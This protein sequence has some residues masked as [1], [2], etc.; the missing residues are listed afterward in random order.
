MIRIYIMLAVAGVVFGGVKYFLHMQ[1]QMK[2]MAA[3]NAKLEVVAQENEIMMTN[4]MAETQRMNELNNDLRN[5][6]DDAKQYQNELIAKLKKHDL[7]K[8]SYAKPS[9][10]EKRI[11]NGTQKLFDELESISGGT[12]HSDTD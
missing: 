7:S 2:Q 5:R 3:N 4:M 6:L 12:V 8:L 11:N 9:L 10:I 1:D